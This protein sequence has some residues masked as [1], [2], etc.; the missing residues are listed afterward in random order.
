MAYFCESWQAFRI[1]IYGALL[2]AGTG[3]GNPREGVSPP[4]LQFLVPGQ[5]IRLVVCPGHSPRACFVLSFR[6]KNGLD[7]ID[8]QDLREPCWLASDLSLDTHGWDRLNNRQTWHHQQGTFV[9]Q[10]RAPPPATLPPQPSTGDSKPA[11]SSAGTLV[12]QVRAP[13]PA[14]QPDGGP[15]SLR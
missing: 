12:S 1:F 7:C 8:L 2:W 11:L 6:D 13:P 14:P 4:G 9:S 15:R 10:V 3:Q 5:E